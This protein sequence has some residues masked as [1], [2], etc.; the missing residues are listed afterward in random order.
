MSAD[1]VRL[2]RRG[3]RDGAQVCEVRR[4]DDEDYARGYVDGRLALRTATEAFRSTI[5]MGPSAVASTNFDH[6]EPP[7]F[8]GPFDALKA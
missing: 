8:D 2:Y 5:G 1:R 4:P 6:T 7:T 3:F